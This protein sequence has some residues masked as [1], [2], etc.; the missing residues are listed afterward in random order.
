MKKYLW[1]LAIVLIGSVTMG[2]AQK[3]DRAAAAKRMTDSM[4]VKLQL[5]TEQVPKV[6]AINE[7]WASKAA[8]IRSEEGERMEKAK[9]IK[10]ANQ[11]RDKALK[12]VLTESQYA[13]Y[14]AN[15]KELKKEAK[16]RMRDR[17]KN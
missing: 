3:G 16:G 11:D 6:Q 1:A 9:K 12:E 13:D 14:V 17:K 15:K 8:A 7:T 2:Y 5:T 4:T 10:E